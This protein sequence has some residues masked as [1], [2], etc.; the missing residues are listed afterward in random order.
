MNAALQ[1]LFRIIPSTF[2]PKEAVV[3]IAGEAN[4]PD[5]VVT[6]FWNWRYACLHLTGREVYQYAREMRKELNSANPKLFE[7]GEEGFE[8]ECMSY[9]LM[10]LMDV[11]S[12][13]GP[14][15][16]HTTVSKLA[17]ATKGCPASPAKIDHSNLSIEV[18]WPKK[19]SL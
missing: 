14:L 17:C 19:W 11:N 8:T 13:L 1:I 2:N 18:P 3:P 6:C 16:E 12:K 9:I 7:L 15:F 5:S 10:K 4:D